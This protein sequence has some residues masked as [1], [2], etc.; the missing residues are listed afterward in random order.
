MIFVKKKQ[1]YFRIMF[2][3]ILTLE[4]LGGSCSTTFFFVTNVKTFI[5]FYSETV[6]VTFLLPLFIETETSVCH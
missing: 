1:S 3:H 2:L 5:A 4:K 6:A